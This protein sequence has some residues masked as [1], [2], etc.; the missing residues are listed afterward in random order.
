MTTEGSDLIAN[1]ADAVSG[2][3][4]A[5]RM[6]KQGCRVNL[7]QL[8]QERLIIDVDKI[9]PYGEDKCDY[10][11]FSNQPLIAP[12]EMKRGGVGASEAQRQLQAGANLADRLV[13]PKR[14]KC[15][16]KPIVVSGRIDRAE[17]YLL[18]DSRYFVRFRNEF[19]EIK[20]AKCGAALRDALG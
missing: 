2:N 5:R 11:F 17:R 16:V 7:D 3:S 15:D 6:R 4:I 20:A 8:E 12:I 9:V 18:R 10:L 1:V 14:L 13:V 19:F